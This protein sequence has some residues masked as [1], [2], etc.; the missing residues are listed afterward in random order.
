MQTVCQIM[1]IVNTIY[2]ISKKYNK[3][4][5]FPSQI[6]LQKILLKQY[7]IKRSISTINRWLRIVE[8]LGY[9]KRVRRIRKYSDGGYKFS[10]TL[11]FLKIKGLKKL[12]SLSYDVLQAIKKYYA[13]FTTAQGDK[14]ATAAIEQNNIGTI[15]VDG[16]QYKTIKDKP[17]TS[18]D[19]GVQLPSL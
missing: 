12:K 16:K 7:G 1:P 14:Q 19:F 5:C 18:S 8:D 10:T 4:Y 11:Y 2:Q 15:L 3:H 17:R 13:K 9:I 6:T